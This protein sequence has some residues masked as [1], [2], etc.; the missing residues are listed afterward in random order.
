MKIFLKAVA[1]LLLLMLAI[2]AIRS[3]S[4]H[5]GYVSAA[6]LAE[7]G[8][9]AWRRAPVWDDGKAE[10]CAYEVTWAHYGRRYPGRALLVLVKE[11]WAPDLDVKADSP[12]PDGFDVLK[13]NHVRDVPTGVYT[14]HQMASLYT[15]RDS[16]AL[17]K[18]AA[19]SS[20]ACGIT[21]AEMVGGRLATR[22]Y[23][24]GQGDRATNWP[25][26]ALPEDGLPASLRDYVTGRPPASLEVFPSLLAG[27]LPDLKPAAYRVERREVPSVET[28]EGQVPGV[29]IRLT[30][31]PSVLSYTFDRRAPYR[32]LR[33]EGEDG[34]AYRLAKCERIPYWQMSRPGDEKWLPWSAR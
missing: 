19:S 4:G 22:S 10:V 21:T 5:D 32:L 27:R 7:G 23:F 28:P 15:R 6:P 20:E 16:G 8:D 3:D 31:G 34:T 11:P 1:A 14:Y 13:L 26:G 33:F 30:S 2:W 9:P 24:D 29:E 18:L 17:Q 25:A 12:R